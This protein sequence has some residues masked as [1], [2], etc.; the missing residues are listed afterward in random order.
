MISSCDGCLFLE[1]ADRK[2]RDKLE[3]VKVAH[4][5]FEGEHVALMPAI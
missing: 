2:S 3:N 4:N 5:E 1:E